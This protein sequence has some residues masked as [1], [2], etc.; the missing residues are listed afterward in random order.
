MRRWIV[1]TVLA[2]GGLMALGPLVGR[3]DLSN[4][5]RL[6]L[7]RE[8]AIAEARR[9]AKAHGVNA[10]GW[11]PL[12]RAS[13][14]QA[15]A[16]LE[17][18]ARRPVHPLFT[19]AQ[20]EV[21]L[22]APHGRRA[23]KIV[24]TSDGRPVSF[25]QRFAAGEP[26]A[27]SAV[28]A[29]RLKLL[30]TADFEQFRRENEQVKQGEGVLDSW[31]WPAPEPSLSSTRFE[32]VTEK[33][34]LRSARLELRLPAE[35][36]DR[37]REESAR[38]TAIL[39]SVITVVGGLLYSLAF[40]LFFRGMVRRRIPMRLVWRV[41]ALFAA[42]MVLAMA[43]KHSVTAAFVARD[44][45]SS[46][47]SQIPNTLFGWM[48]LAT[49]LALFYGA[50]RTLLND[51]DL[52]RWFSFE[53]LAAG[54]IADR[55]VGRSLVAGVLCGCA[56]TVLPFAGMVLG[57]PANPEMVSVR[58]AL[59]S[60]PMLA[61]FAFAGVNE[62]AA[63]LLL[64]LPG[65]NRLPYRLGWVGY[66]VVGGLI[67]GILR[68]LFGFWMWPC[69]LAGALLALAYAAVY[70]AFDL[71]AALVAHTVLGVAPLAV[72]MSLQPAGMRM[73][74]LSAVSLPLLGLAWG[75]V[76]MWRGRA[77]DVDAEIA[78][79]KAELKE[80]GS[81]RDRLRAEFSVARKA[82]L[83][84]LPDVPERIGETTLAALCHPARE[85]GGDLYDFFRGAD[86]RYAICVADVSG[87][88]VP[89]SLY[90]SLTKGIMAAASVESTAIPELLGTLNKHL[91]EFGKRRM[92]VT[93]ALGYYDPA[94]RVL[95][96][97]RAGHNPVLVWSARAATA[98]F[99][100]TRGVGL[101]LAG[102]A[103]F[104]KAL[105]VERVSLEPDDVVVFYSDGIVEA[106]NMA[107][108]Q[109]GEDRLIDAVRESARLSAEAIA[110]EIERR[111]RLFAGAAPVHDD[112]TLFV[113][114]V[115]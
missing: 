113:M 73:D 47:A 23:V 28:S 24:L 55:P 86:G 4:T 48:I 83:G 35:F 15:R 31:I 38:Q 5:W 77:V 37:F 105:Q 1:A 114:R 52:L 103:S 79:Q 60:W 17:R 85:V 100:K 33:G 102:A 110:E 16:Y 61:P 109:F 92:F 96:H 50:G 89:A 95:E 78:R 101:G 12:C 72:A 81:D 22:L 94:T 64:I 71:L 54:R 42:I 36:G 91:L 46:E 30:Y 39:S 62:A 25:E 115:G 70:F 21:S 76:V 44:T 49:T 93:M 51:A 11:S 19:A 84:M 34:A 98:D 10:D 74:A 63:L 75:L 27:P 80:A 87:K 32:V 99:L 82:Q 69:L 45:F 29:D 26:I 67:T 108:E 18:K 90:M 106:M 59:T 104:G 111:V 58:D 9:L 57:P 8:D 2:L 112:Q 53:R 66:V 20:Y 43:D 3:F 97:A 40:P 107:Q 68:D 13:F 41:G 7:T 88:G 56:L 65:R 14:V 6:R